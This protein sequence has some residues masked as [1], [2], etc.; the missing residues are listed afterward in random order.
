MR[1][2]KFK[3]HVDHLL[4]QHPDCNPEIEDIPTYVMPKISGTEVMGPVN[5]K[6][7][8]VLIKSENLKD[9]K[10]RSIIESVKLPR[11]AKEKSH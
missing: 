3:C 2:K 10:N 9:R 8:L 6:P 4:S 5:P 1:D 7:A 11:V